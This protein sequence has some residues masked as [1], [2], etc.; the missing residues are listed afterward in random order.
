M[1]TGQNGQRLLRIV[2]A[3]LVLG[4]LVHAVQALVSAPGARPLFN[5]G[6]HNLLMLGGV[7]LC[8]ARGVSVR[9]ERAAWLAMAG[10]EIPVGARIIAVCDSYDAITSK[11]AY[12]DARSH[13]AALIALQRCAGSQFDP[14]VVEAF[15]A[16]NPAPFQHALLAS[17]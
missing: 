8:F 2:I 6:L 11:R 13:K 9:P 5:D 12:A 14:V 10:Y 3:V 16:G 4:V 17:A 7:G 1:A 15:C